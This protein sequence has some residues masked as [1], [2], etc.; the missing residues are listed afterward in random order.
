MEGELAHPH[1][2]LHAR[3]QAFKIPGFQGQV[4]FITSMSEHFCGTC[5]RLRITADG[6]LKVSVYSPTGPP[7]L[8]ALYVSFQPCPLIGGEALRVHR[9]DGEIVSG[10]GGSWEQQ[11][12]V[13]LWLPWNRLPGSVVA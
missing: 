11:M 8:C 4:S 10:L 13:N 7:P 9:S 5:N 2:L 3:P 1:L 6:N 12:G